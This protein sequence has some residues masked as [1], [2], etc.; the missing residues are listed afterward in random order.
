[1]VSGCQHRG[2]DFR[3]RRSSSEPRRDCPGYRAE[4]RPAY[5][6]ECWPP[7]GRKPDYLLA[8]TGGK[9]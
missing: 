2:S 1:M 9:G 5:R 8:L 7:S 4:N 6:R 3:A